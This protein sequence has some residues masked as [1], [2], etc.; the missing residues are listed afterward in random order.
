MAFCQTIF[1]KL[2]FLFMTFF[3]LPKLAIIGFP[4]LI[5]TVKPAEGCQGLSRATK[6]NYVIQQYHAYYGYFQL[7]DLGNGDR[8]TVTA[9]MS[10]NATNRM[11]KNAAALEIS[12]TKQFQ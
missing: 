9:K 2:S 10:G 12:Y 4:W 7:P 3:V 1:Q 6:I 5:L 11:P 8:M